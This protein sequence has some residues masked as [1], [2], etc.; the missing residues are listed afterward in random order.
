MQRV[1]IRELALVALAGGLLAFEVVGLKGALPVAIEALQ[2]HGIIDQVDAASSEAATAAASA[3]TTAGPS[4]TR[5][6]ADLAKQAAG[7]AGERSA[8]A[9]VGSRASVPTHVVTRAARGRAYAYVITVTDP[10]RCP[11]AASL[12]KG[13]RAD[14]ARRVRAMR[15]SAEAVRAETSL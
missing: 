11:H 3:L 6:A 2:Q 13:R 10:Q 14:V 12:S 4:A 15:R 1:R 5:A 7:I 8:Q 9:I